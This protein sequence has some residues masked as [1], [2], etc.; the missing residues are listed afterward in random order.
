[1]LYEKDVAVDTT[2]L[3]TDHL[4]NEA[5]QGS[6]SNGNEKEGFIR[7]KEKGHSIH[8]SSDL[9]AHKKPYETHVSKFSNKECL[10]NKDATNNTLQTEGKLS[11]SS[12]SLPTNQPVFGAGNPDPQAD[13]HH[14]M[15]YAA[16]VSEGNQ[17]SSDPRKS[18]LDKDRIGTD[19]CSKLST[20]SQAAKKDQHFG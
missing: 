17:E 16:A 19:Q 2:P 20:R 14:G 8:N 15:N 18:T 9:V 5:L 1:M 11:I 7:N 13:A 6:L 3:V 10:Q 12:Q 4:C